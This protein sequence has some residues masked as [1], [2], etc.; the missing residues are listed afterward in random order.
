M[1]GHMRLP[2]HGFLMCLAAVALCAQDV[3]TIQRDEP[4]AHP[5]MSEEAVRRAIERLAGATGLR[6]RKAREFVRRFSPQ[7]VQE[8]NS[9]KAC[10]VLLLEAP[11]PEDRHFTMPAARPVDPP[12][13]M[14]EAHLP[15]PP[16]A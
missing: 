15:A 16:C 12:P 6:A 7:S 2:K 5:Y 4:P 3:K 11:A 14:P 8:L 13:P 10:A 1:I 9:P